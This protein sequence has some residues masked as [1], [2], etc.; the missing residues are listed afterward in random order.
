M[1][2]SLNICCISTFVFNK[3]KFVDMTIIVL[4]GVTKKTSALKF[5]A[6][7]LCPAPS[8]SLFQGWEEKHVTVTLDSEGYAGFSVVGGCDQPQLPSPGAFFITMVNQGGPAEG[9]LKYVSRLKMS[10][11]AYDA[12]NT[13]HTGNGGRKPRLHH[14]VTLAISSRSH[15]HAIAGWKPCLIEEFNQDRVISGVHGF[16]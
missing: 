7:V 15:V 1:G 5:V 3:P 13:P 12:Y 6:T 16:C 8:L 10:L 14:K 11:R 2:K 9:L 4:I